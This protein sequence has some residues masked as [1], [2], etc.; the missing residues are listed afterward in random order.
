MVGLPRSSSTA[1][2]TLALGLREEIVK[3]GKWIRCPFS[4]PRPLWVGG[5]APGLAPAPETEPWGRSWGVREPGP[6][7]LKGL[8][9][10]PLLDAY[11]GPAAG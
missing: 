9:M 1:M 2:V 5:W 10:D 3:G 6:L 8:M 7:S 4:G 11:P